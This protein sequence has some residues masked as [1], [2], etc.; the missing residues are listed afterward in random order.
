MDEELVEAFL[1]GVDN[2]FILT[3]L[4]NKNTKARFVSM[5]LIKS[6]AIWLHN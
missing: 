1:Q 2:Y 5:L 3:G 6:A 4:T